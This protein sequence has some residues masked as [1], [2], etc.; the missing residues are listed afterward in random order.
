MKSVCSNNAIWIFALMLILPGSVPHAED[1]PSAQ[2]QVIR[3]GQP[4]LT[5][6]VPSALH[7]A[8]ASSLDEAVSFGAKAIPTPP[9]GSWGIV[10]EG[11]GGGGIFR[12]SDSEAEAWLGTNEYGVM[13]FGSAS[14]GYFADSD[15]TSY[16]YVGYG[17]YGIQ[18][19]GDTLGGVFADANASGYVYAGWGDEG[20]LASGDLR[21]GHFSDADGTGYSYVGIGHRGIEA[22]GTE[23]GGYFTDSDNLGYAYVGYGD[24]GIHGYGNAAGG[25]FKDSDS[26]GYAW[27]GFGDRGIEAYGTEMGG[28]FKDSDGTGYAHVWIGLR[29]IEAYGTEMGG[30][31]EDSDGTGYARVGQFNTGIIAAGAGLGGFFEAT[32]SSGQAYVGWGDY[33]IEASGTGAGGF[34]HNTSSSSYTKVAEGDYGIYALG[35]VAGGY[36]QD[37][38]S[39]TFARVGYSAFKIAGSGTVS[40]VQNHPYVPSSVIVYNAP[41][42]DE[43]ATYTRGTAKL[44]DGEARVPLGETFKWVTNPDIGLTAHLTPRED[45]NGVY[46][47]DLSTEEIVVRELQS[48]TSDCAF[49]YLVYG[50]RIGFEESTI[51]QE[52]EQ[53]SYIPSMADHRQL[54]ERRPDLKMYN[55]LERFKGMRRIANPKA[56]LDLSRAQALR[57]AII[58]FD[59]AV[60]EL[61]MPPGFEER[62]VDDLTLEEAQRGAGQRVR[63]ARAGDDRRPATDRSA[64][65]S[66]VPVDNEGNVYAPSFRP[67]SQDL[68]SLVTVS[69]TVEPGDVLVIDTDRRGL[70]RR[71][72]SAADNG[73]VGIVAAAPGVVL[74]SEVEIGQTEAPAERGQ[75][76]DIQLKVPVA[77]SGVV[78]CK[79]DASYGAVWTGNLLVTSPTP[80]HAMAQQAPLPGTVVG[81]A[82]EPLEEGVG[83]IKVLV[84]L[85]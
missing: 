17:D 56:K 47:A 13:G 44:V 28:Y 19:Y 9:T 80:G 76:S 40:F 42:G 64:L 32:S 74:G 53:E 61:P 4:A 78:D 73:V 85:R 1:P 11:D 37:T 65:G 27:A 59:P 45:C 84:M 75:N 18:A 48:G 3:D 15:G 72:S 29:G 8:L 70:M 21:G 52:K 55:S 62:P 58:E 5:A 50:L 35:P 23:M 2:D 43:V 33:G 22:Y 49:D 71:G 69:E 25:Y 66:T 24:R 82:L 81:K 46:L 20:I 54:Y 34:F 68:A 77:F 10:S 7:R 30:Y 38:D 57:D 26:S 60:H 14:G 6:P 16:A 83:T 12:D 63:A 39:G 51:V 67:S 79:V 31:F 41:E 36:F